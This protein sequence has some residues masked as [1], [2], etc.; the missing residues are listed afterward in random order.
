MGPRLVSSPTGMAAAVLIKFFLKDRANRGTSPITPFGKED[1]GHSDD[2]VASSVKGPSKRAMEGRRWTAK[3]CCPFADGH[4]IS[5]VVDT[6]DGR[7]RVRLNGEWIY[8]PESAT[9]TEPNRLGP[10]VVWLMLQG[11]LKSAASC[12]ALAP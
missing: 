12:R 9:V 4:S 2:E 10:A 3:L 5:V 11:L 1:R 6:K 7:Y 8:V